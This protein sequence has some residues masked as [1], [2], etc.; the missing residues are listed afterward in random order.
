MLNVDYW[1]VRVPGDNFDLWFVRG[2]RQDGAQ[3]RGV[4]A[5]RQPQ[6]SPAPPPA[7]HP[8]PAAFNG[9]YP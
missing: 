8:N 5:L 9:Q 2:W 3:L 7:P 6:P 1:V 4:G